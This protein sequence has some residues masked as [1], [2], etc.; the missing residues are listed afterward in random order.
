MTVAHWPLGV[1]AVVFVVDE[2]VHRGAVGRVRG[3][4]P[5]VVVEGGGI[6]V[7]VGSENDRAVVSQVIEIRP[8]KRR[9]MN[10]P[11]S[12]EPVHPH[13]ERHEPAGPGYPV[14]TTVVVQSKTTGGPPITFIL[15]DR[16]AVRDGGGLNRVNRPLASQWKP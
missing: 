2:R 14:L 15:T 5:L 3:G 4:D 10:Q 9:L 12:T 6:G 7:E 16:G 8:M 13:P 11:R 1:R